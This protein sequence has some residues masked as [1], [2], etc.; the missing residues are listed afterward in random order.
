MVKNQFQ[1]P[2]IQVVLQDRWPGRREV[3][4]AKHGEVRKSLWNAVQYFSW[5]RVKGICATGS[6]E[7]IV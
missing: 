6:W 1:L 2:E 3:F 4:R 7:V 5:R